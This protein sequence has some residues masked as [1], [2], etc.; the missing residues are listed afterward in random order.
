MKKIILSLL[1]CF[2]LAACGQPASSNSNSSK[3][4]AVADHKTN[5]DHLE[6]LMSGAD[7]F[8]QWRDQNLQV[9]PDL[10]NAS[11]E[12]AN[13]AGYDLSKAL[14]S[15]ANLATANLEGANLSKANLRGADLS[16]ANISNVNWDA[17]RYDNRTKWP[18]G[19]DPVVAGL[20]LV[21]Q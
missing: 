10:E 14:L 15:N 9:I 7:S 1:I 17:A 11:L 3:T 2:T 8:N 13:L 12:N 20:T 6:K 5:P 19:F 16:N 18:E 21:G 4:E